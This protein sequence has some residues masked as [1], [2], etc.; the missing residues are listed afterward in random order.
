MAPCGRAAA[1]AEGNGAH[2][3]DVLQELGV[4]EAV[5]RGAAVCRVVEER[6]NT[7]QVLL[8][9]K[10]TTPLQD[11]RAQF[12]ARQNTQVNP[13]T[14]RPPTH[15]ENKV[16]RQVSGFV[17]LGIFVMPLMEKKRDLS[18]LLQRGCGEP[19]LLLQVNRGLNTENIRARNSA[20]MTKYLA[21]ALLH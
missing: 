9:R 11:E 2:L 18:L 1:A 20:H 5:L 8:E 6:G 21:F 3:G 12:E 10:H 19:Q 15:L 16:E 13:Q 4:G 17:A 7:R 14:E